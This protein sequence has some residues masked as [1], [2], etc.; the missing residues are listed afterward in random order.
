MSLKNFKVI[1][2]LGTSSHTPYPLHNPH[3]HPPTRRRRLHHR[4][5]GPSNLRQQNLRTKEGQADEPLREAK[6]KLAERGQDPSL[7]PK[8]KRHLTEGG[9]PRRKVQFAM[10]TL[11]TIF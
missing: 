9:I 8:P 2:K 11:K 3:P 5:P 1:S 4:V 10:V 6:N 7:N